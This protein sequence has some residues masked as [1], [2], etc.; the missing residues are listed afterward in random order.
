MNEPDKKKCGKCNEWK[1]VEEFYRAG[2]RNGRQQYAHKCKECEKAD[3][4]EAYHAGRKHQWQ[5]K[6]A[7]IRARSRAQTRL[8]KLVPELYDLILSEELEKEGVPRKPK[9]DPMKRRSITV[10]HERD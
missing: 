10:H 5:H 2:K 7:Y 6:K 9:T 8:T 3:K 4:R 1:D